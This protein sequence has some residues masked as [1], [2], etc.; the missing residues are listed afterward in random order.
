MGGFLDESE[1]TGGRDGRGAV[2]LSF[3]DSLSG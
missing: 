3:F 1:G 2:A